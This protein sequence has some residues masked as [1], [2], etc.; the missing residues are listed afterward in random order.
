MSTLTPAMLARFTQVDYDRELA[1]V[2]VANAGGTSAFVGVARYIANPDGASAEFAVVVADAWQR[3]GV[4]RILMRGLIVCAKRRGFSRLTGAIL[5][6]NEPMI[7]F[8]RSLGFAIE[9]D[10]EDAA[11]VCATLPLN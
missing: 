10:A 2:A 3:R 11:Q 4:A 7:A 6:V 9:D 5:R 8:V 1:L